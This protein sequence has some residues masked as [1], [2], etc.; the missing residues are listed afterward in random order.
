[1]HHA[2]ALTVLFDGPC[3]LCDGLA[4][5][6][7]RHARPGMLRLVPVP[8]DEADGVWAS[9]A[10]PGDPSLA[11]LAA[12]TVI[13][14]DRSDGVVIRTHSD[15][16]LAVAARLRWP[17]RAAGWLRVLP[18]GWRDGLYR[19]VAARRGR[20]GRRSC[21]RPSSKTFHTGPARSE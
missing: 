1:M 21:E 16:A 13:A 20:F 4:G 5:W 3:T 18:E 6:A 8:S 19:A 11:D 9:V 14:V 2:E 7:A 12:E 15:A 10:G 17:W